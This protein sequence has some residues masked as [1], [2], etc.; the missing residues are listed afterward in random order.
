MYNDGIL[1]LVIAI[2]Y[3]IFAISMVQSFNFGSNEMQFGYRYSNFAIN[4]ENGIGSILT[5]VVVNFGYTL[6]EMFVKPQN[7]AF[8]Q[9]KF[10]FILWMFVPVLLT[11][12]RNSKISTLL[13]LS[14]MLLINLMPCWG[15]QYDIEYQ[16]TY[17]TAAMVII[18]TMLALKDMSAKQR[19]MLLTA[20]VILC[21]AITAP[22][23]VTKNNSYIGKYLEKQKVFSESVE[24]IRNTIDKSCAVGTE[25][26]VTP[27]LYDYKIVYYDAHSDQLAPKIEY[28]V[29]KVGDSDINEMISKGFVRV[30]GNSYIEIYKNINF[31][32]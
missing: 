32:R 9:E 10:V 2:C 1:T 18:C 15:Y 21:F 29:T 16:Y 17:G 6:K 30:A 12:F 23:T 31:N 8:T 22:I 28:N 11:P 5:T 27:M 26:D 14:P 3:F 19:N 13:L 24:L 25:G 7:E 20:S 4:G